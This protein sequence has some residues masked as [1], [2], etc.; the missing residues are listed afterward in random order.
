MKKV[1]MLQ[2]RKI[3]LDKLFE[4][5]GYVMF[6]FYN[7]QIVMTAKDVILAESSFIN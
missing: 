2:Y 1:I 3:F 7:K 4:R 5:E 6:N